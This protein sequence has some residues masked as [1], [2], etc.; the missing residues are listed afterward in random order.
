M[1]GDKIFIL[2]IFK[3][4]NIGK[5]KIQR[6]FWK[7]F[8]GEPLN[9]FNKGLAMFKFCKM[10][11]LSS[12][13]FLFAASLSLEAK[14][15]KISDFAGNFVNWGYSAGGIGDG[16]ETDGFGFS[17]VNVTQSTTD[18]NG[19]GTINFISYS[20]YT[21]SGSLIVLSSFPPTSVPPIN[22]TVN[23]IDPVHIA[24]T[25]TIV[26]FPVTGDTIVYQFVGKKCDGKIQKLWSNA[27]SD[28]GP[29]NPTFAASILFSERQ[30]D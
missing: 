6:L 19:N 29:S 5:K 2:Q 18:K 3:S 30:S 27:V 11:T 12:L 9:N 23:L 24:G 15:A 20:I 4:L 28:S 22:F 21:G 8:P 25:L 16:N 1:R 7:N 13:A 10:L 26:D 17:Q 14:D